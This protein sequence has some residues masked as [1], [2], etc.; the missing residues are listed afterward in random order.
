MHMLCAQE[1]MEPELYLAVSSDRIGGGVEP[2]GGEGETSGEG[3]LPPKAVSP[4]AA[5]FLTTAVS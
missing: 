2:G 4:C 5:T 3:H 1:G